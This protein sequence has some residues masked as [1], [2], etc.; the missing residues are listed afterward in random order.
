MGLGVKKNI[1]FDVLKIRKLLFGSHL[2]L[3]FSK[4]DL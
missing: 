1:F 3:S 4:N 2:E